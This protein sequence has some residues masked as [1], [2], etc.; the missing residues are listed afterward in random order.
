[1]LS[2]LQGAGPYLT[3]ASDGFFLNLSW[4]LL[5]LSTP[6]AKLD[7][8]GI[9]PRLRNIDPGY[10]VILNRKG[11]TQRDDETN[12]ETLRGLVVDFSQET[13][14]A[15]IEETGNPDQYVY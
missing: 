15:H 2:R 7:T 9:N 14:L 11:S 5:L 3:T 8:E 13:K 1:M 10:C 4:V 6:F 12:V